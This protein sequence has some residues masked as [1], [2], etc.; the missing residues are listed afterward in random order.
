MFYTHT[1]YKQIEVVFC[2]L[3]FEKKGVCVEILG[4]NVHDLR[5]TFQRAGI[6]CIMTMKCHHHHQYHHYD[7]HHHH[8]FLFM[9][10]GHCKETTSE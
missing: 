9:L 8:F 2:S 10:A 6:I 4:E 7:H 3:I 5:R 1:R